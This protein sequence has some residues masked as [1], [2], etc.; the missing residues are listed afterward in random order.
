M[1]YWYAVCLSLM[2]MGCSTRTVI[3][4]PPKL[5]FPLPEYVPAPNVKWKV[6]TKETIKKEKDVDVFVGLSYDDSIELRKW[7]ETI[8]VHIQKQKL[9]ICNHQECDDQ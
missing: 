1:R 7:L 4:E 2:L 3:V 5:T 9:I 8:K 6:L